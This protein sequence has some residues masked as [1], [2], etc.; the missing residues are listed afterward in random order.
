MISSDHSHLRVTAI[1][2][3]G[4]T[5]KNNEDRYGVSA[6]HLAGEPAVPSVF[7]AVADGVGGH[8]AGEVAA[9]MAIETISAFIAQSDGSQPVQTLQQAIVYA[10][11]VINRKAEEDATL[12][13][14]GSTCACAWVIGSRLYTVSV[15]DSR[16]YLIR[17]GVIRQLT[18]DHTWVQEAIE[19]GVIRPEEAR[20]HPN[21]HVIRRY[22]GSRQ[23]TQPDI[24]LRLHPEESDALSETN[25]GAPLLPGDILVLCTDGLTDLVDDHEIMVS[26]RSRNTAGAL[27]EMVRLTN[28]RGGHDNVTIVTL[29]NP[30][31]EQPT[32]PLPRQPAQPLR[33][34]RTRLVLYLSLVILLFLALFSALAWSTIWSARSRTLTPSPSPAAQET[35]LPAAQPVPATGTAVPQDPPLWTSTPAP[36]R[37]PTQTLALPRA[38][39]TPWPTNTP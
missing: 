17:G 20:Y 37:R 2:H 8:R 24:R 29:A 3:P 7:A 26:L 34:R 4:M 27:E 1:S 39:L 18:T 28:R 22:L 21:A 25:Q 35:L 30:T 32:T 14:M 11:R 13:G 15:G 19:H 33:P 10:N 6:F 31:L 16:I 5:G 23:D 9:E 38:T 12:Q 36:T